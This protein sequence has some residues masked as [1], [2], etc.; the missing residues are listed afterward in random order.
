MAVLIY[1]SEV[2]HGWQRVAVPAHGM[3]ELRMLIHNSVQPIRMDAIQ[4]KL[5]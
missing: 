4:E 1:G 3:G 5:D 2:K